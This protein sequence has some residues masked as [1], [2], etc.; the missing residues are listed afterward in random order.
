MLIIARIT[1]YFQDFGRQSREAVAG[2]YSFVFFRVYFLFFLLLNSLLWFAAHY[3]IQ[4]IGEPRI[5][6]H[7][8][9][10]TGI[11]YYGAAWQ[12]YFLPALGA[13]FFLLN[14]FIFVFFR[15][16][17]DRRFLGHSL[18]A[19][20]LMSNLFLFAGLASVYLINFK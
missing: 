14:T 9:V 17:A 15:H 8:N 5:A 12:L 20:A 10:D 16:Q 19:I 1:N 4:A 3:T 11:D 18:L 6:L 7:Y 2:L 13:L